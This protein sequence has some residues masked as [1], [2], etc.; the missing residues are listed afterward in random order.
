MRVRWK[1]L[2]AS[3]VAIAIGTVIV[4]GAAP[5][6]R[7]ESA[8]DSAAGIGGDSPSPIHDPSTPYPLGPHVIPYEA[9]SDS[10]RRAVD[11]VRETVETSQPASSHDAYAAAAASIQV[12]AERQR[13]ERQVGLVGTEDDGVVP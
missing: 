10:E 12:D 13:A 6:V 3:T 4:V 5:S 2:G 8:A 11:I 1:V 7:E 9:L